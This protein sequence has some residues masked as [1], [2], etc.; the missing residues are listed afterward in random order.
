[1]SDLT[2]VRADRSANRR[3]RP[4]RL[5]E[6]RRPASSR[7]GTGPAAGRKPDGGSRSGEDVTRKRPGRGLLR[8]RDV[9]HQRNFTS[10]AAI[11]RSDGEDRSTRGISS[12]GGVAPHPGAGN[13]G[14]GSDAG[15]PGKPHG[16][17]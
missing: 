3:L 16:N 5:T 2:P 12:F 15:R 9:Y 6:T 4:Q 14:P 13:R 11:V 8:P 10:C 7:T 17:A 1:G